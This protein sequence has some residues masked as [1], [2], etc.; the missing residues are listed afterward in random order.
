MTPYPRVS[1]CLLAYNHASIL[2]DT[3]R[4]LLS[5]TMGDFELILS[6]DQSTDATW[7]VIRQ[8]AATDPRVRAVQTPRNLGMAGN[9][10]YAVGL[11]SAPYVALLHHDDLYSPELL[12][13]WLEVIESSD[14]IAFVANAYAFFDSPKVDYHGFRRHHDGRDALE[15]LL[16]PGWGCPV[17]GTALIRASAW[18]ALGGMRERFG[19]IA[20]V[21]LWMR[22]AARWDVGYVREPLI[23][24]RQERPDDYPEGYVRWSWPRMRLLYEIH[25]ANRRDYF[26]SDTLRGR[27]EM[28][29]Y[30]LRVNADELRWLAYA[31]AR[32][33]TDILDDSDNVANE[34]ELPG[35]V[36]LR[37]ALGVASRAV[38]NER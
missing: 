11:A 31:V 25:G 38:S 9:A 4:S 12:E 3:V 8:L 32:R 35:V 37:K 17:R 34:Y 16:F 33:R 10:N 15:R 24:V 36:L 29:K 20:D 7:S 26:G 14:R 30:R 18:R 21:D 13:R 28:V 2:A 1:V 6:D 27:L 19:L 5:Q 22:L 23:T